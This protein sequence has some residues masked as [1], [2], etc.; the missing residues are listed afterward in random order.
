MSEKVELYDF[1]QYAVIETGS[2]FKFP[3]HD[4]DQI[5]F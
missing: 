4:D 3:I 5:K 2:N 1:T